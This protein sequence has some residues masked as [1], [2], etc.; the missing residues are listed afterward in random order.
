M[1]EEL[2]DHVVVAGLLQKGPRIADVAGLT[3]EWFADK[4]ASKLFHLAAGY[5]QKRGGKITLDLPLA[6][7]LLERAG[8]TK[9]ERA[10]LLDLVAEYEGFAPISDAEFRD[11]LVG[12]ST[13][14]ERTVLRHHVAAAAEAMAEEDVEKAKRALRNALIG[15]E[16]VDVTDDQ[17]SNVRSA[18][19]IE[20]ERKRSHEIRPDSSGTFEVGLPWLTEKVRFKRRELTIIG[21]Y[22]ADGKTTLAKSFVYNANQTGARCLY[23]ALEMDKQEIM[24]LFVAQHASTLD[25]RGVEWSRMLDGTADLETKKRYH[26]AL[27]DFEVKPYEDGLEVTSSTGAALHVWAPTKQITIGQYCERARAIKEDQGLDVAAADYLELI[28]PDRDLGQYRLNV[29]DM[30]K[31][32]KVLARELDIWQLVPHQ[33]GR[34][35]RA[36]AEKRTPPHYHLGDL[37]ESSGV[38]Q[39]ADTVVLIYSDDDHKSENQARVGLPKARKGKTHTQGERV[40]ADFPHSVIAAL[41]E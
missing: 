34:K 5:H 17:P 36:D 13:S 8:G 21:G 37:G 39:A 18:A 27:D 40:F 19:E 15:A 1:S 31:R 3:P 12:L 2:H 4:E 6:R 41:P 35:G 29:R 11:A 38:E 22:T 10:K 16:E 33:I 23:V 9:K 7:S 28:E 20:R 32:F 25:D 30:A 24:T 26:R 14:R